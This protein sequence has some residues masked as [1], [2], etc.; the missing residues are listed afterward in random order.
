MHPAHGQGVAINYDWWCYLVMIVGGKSVQNDT[1]RT[2]SNI[3]TQPC[4]TR[5]MVSNNWCAGRQVEA[6][7]QDAWHV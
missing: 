4:L 3:A 5:D 6:I 2:S 1:R 7:E